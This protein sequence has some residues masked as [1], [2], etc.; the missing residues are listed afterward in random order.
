MNKK[1]RLVLQQSRQKNQKTSV[2]IWHFLSSVRG[3]SELENA[4][5]TTVYNRLLT[6]QLSLSSD[7][8][9]PKVIWQC[10]SM[11][12]SKLAERAK[13]LRHIQHCCRSFRVFFPRRLPFS[14]CSREPSTAPVLDCD[15]DVQVHFDDFLCLRR[16]DLNL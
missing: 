12:L 8:G 13:L 16:Q 4:T 7:S 3:I 15:D 10:L 1:I 9:P 2:V 5:T 14:S 11:C 6:F